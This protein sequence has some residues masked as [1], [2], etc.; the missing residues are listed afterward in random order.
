MVHLIISEKDPK[1]M[2]IVDG[3]KS[4]SLAHQ[5]RFESQRIEPLMIAYGKEY[6]GFYPI[7]IGLIE[8]EKLVEGWYECRCDKYEN[9]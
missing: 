2:T 6:E 5:I 8:L 9:D 4:L 3:I 1:Q 7:N